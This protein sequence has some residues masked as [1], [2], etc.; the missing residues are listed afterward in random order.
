MAHNG[1]QSL[2]IHPDS[3]AIVIVP[4]V[5][6][7]TTQV[8]GNGV[9]IYE[10]ACAVATE[11]GCILIGRVFIYYPLHDGQHAVRVGGKEV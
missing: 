3:L 2:R 7:G 1:S 9:S 6:I 10:T 8:G 4:S 5:G 11:D